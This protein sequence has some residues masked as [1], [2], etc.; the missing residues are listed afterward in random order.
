MAEKVVDVFLK[1]RLVASYPIVLD[2]L[3]VAMSEQDFIQLTRNSMRED[4][5]PAEDIADAKFSVRSVPE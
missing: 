2:R 3:N 1:D 5:Y 4:G